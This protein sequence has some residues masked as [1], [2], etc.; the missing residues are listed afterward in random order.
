MYLPIKIMTMLTFKKKQLYKL[1]FLKLTCLA[2]ALAFTAI[3]CKKDR[4]NDDGYVMSDQEFVLS[5][6]SSNNFEV[7][8]GLLADKKGTNPA[9][10]EYGA[11]M[12]AD[13]TVAGAELKALADK[14]GWRIS[15]QL[16]LKEQQDLGVLTAA[17]TADF[18]RKFAE[19]MVFSHQQAVQLFEIAASER[20]LPDAELRTLAKSKLPTLKTHLQNAIT[21]RSAV[22]T[23]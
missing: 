11:H 17:A 10:K 7:A 4:H 13:H 18:D 20:G 6:S 2:L 9:V 22:V 15:Q 19:I 1:S 3:S 21:L 5:A 23:P 12:V 14:R 16:S 8:A